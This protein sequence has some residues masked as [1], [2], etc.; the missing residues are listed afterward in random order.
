MVGSAGFP[1]L[2]E[3]H[4]LEITLLIAL[5]VIREVESRGSFG[6][7]WQVLHTTKALFRYTDQ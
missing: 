3:F 1:S 7:A 5:E 2:N 6:I 4:I